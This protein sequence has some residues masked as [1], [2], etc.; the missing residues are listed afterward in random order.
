MAEPR[1]GGTGRPEVPPRRTAPT[2]TAPTRT[3][4]P[5]GPALTRTP[6]TR[7]APPE[8][9][10]ARAAAKAPFPPPEV[11]E[12][13]PQPSLGELV[14]NASTQMSVLVRSEI[15]LAKLELKVEAKKAAIGAAGF[16]AAAFLG[17]F[18]LL[19]LSFAAA[20]GINSMGLAKGW[21]FLIVGGSY[22]LL[23]GLLAFGG[24]KS[25]TQIGPPKRTLR[26]TKETIKVLKETGRA[27]GSSPA[28]ETGI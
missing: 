5:T 21:S 6:P 2:R 24:L 19:M 14:A 16:G 17:L 27:V 22:L 28:K 3:T 11:Q 15:E 18:A 20:Y 10:P 8:P 25:V 12:A 23:A 7:S 9:A 1:P 26:T 13:P 4:P